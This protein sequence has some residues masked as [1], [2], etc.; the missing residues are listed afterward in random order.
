MIVY[1][2]PLILHIKILNYVDTEN[3]AFQ[4]LHYITFDAYCFLFKEED[5][6]S[7][8]V[9]PPSLSLM[10]IGLHYFQFYKI[11]HLTLGI[12]KKDMQNIPTS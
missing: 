12:A 11:S 3:H 2:H 9:P 6:L 4:I 7:C 5:F 1:F 10:S 8:K